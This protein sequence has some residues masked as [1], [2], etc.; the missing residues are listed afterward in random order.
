MEKI[1]VSEDIA[2]FMVKKI[3]DLPK[4]SPVYPY[5]LFC[6]CVE[7]FESKTNLTYDERCK[8]FA[9]AFDLMGHLEK[10]GYFSEKENVFVSTKKLDNFHIEKVVENND[11]FDFVSIEILEVCK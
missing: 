4:D 2:N 3:S 5:N 10:L 6:D 1:F 8:I 9:M 11:S 7:E